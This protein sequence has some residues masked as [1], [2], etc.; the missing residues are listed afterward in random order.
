[1]VEGEPEAPDLSDNHSMRGAEGRGKRGRR[2]RISNGME[3]FWD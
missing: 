2:L 1:M 3:I